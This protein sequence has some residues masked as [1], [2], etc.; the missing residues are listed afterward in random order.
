LVDINENGSTNTISI[1][2]LKL[3]KSLND[4]QNPEVTIFGTLN[5]IV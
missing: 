2:E 1:K 3:I 4:I 5:K